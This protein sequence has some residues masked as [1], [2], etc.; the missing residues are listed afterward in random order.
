MSTDILIRPVA[1]IEE[2][3][4]VEQPWLVFLWNDDVNSRG[5][6]IHALVKVLECA[7]E[8]A[9][10]LMH[11]ADGNG[12]TVVFS[13]DLEKATAVA[14]GLHSWTLNATVGQDT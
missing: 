7:R 1:T 3:L 8:K 14:T 9:A 12:K 2:S 10:Q 4:D 11:E 13:G 6:V 5:Y